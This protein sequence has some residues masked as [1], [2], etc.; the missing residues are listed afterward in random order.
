[1]RKDGSVSRPPWP[2]FGR[3]PRDNRVHLVGEGRLEDRRLLT[4]AITSSGVRS[5]H[6][7]ASVGDGLRLVHLPCAFHRAR[8]VADSAMSRVIAAATAG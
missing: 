2:P 3:R 7:L 8:A 4:L 5:F 1:M 6:L